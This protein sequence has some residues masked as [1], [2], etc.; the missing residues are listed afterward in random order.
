EYSRTMRSF[1][2][3]DETVTRS[4]TGTPVEFIDP[5]LQYP[6]GV[7]PN[8]F[9]QIDRLKISADVTDNTRLYT[10]LF[11]GDTKNRN[12]NTH[13]HFGGF[14]LRVINRSFDGLTLTGYTKWYEERNQKPTTFPEDDLFPDGRKPS[15]EVRHP[16]DR[17]RTTAGL[18]GSWRPFRCD[19]SWRSGLSLIG[20]YEYYS[21]QRRYVTY[22][23]IGAPGAEDTEFTQPDTFANVMH[24]GTQMQ[25][26]QQ[27]DTF[28]RYKMAAIDDPLF[29]V[30]ESD[31]GTVDPD[32]QLSSDITA[33]NTNQPRHEDIIQFGGNW[34]PT[35]NFLMS[36][37]VGI[38]IAS[39]RSAAARFDEA[40]YPI[41]LTAWYAPTCRWSL[42][43]GLAFY[44]NWIDQDITFGN[45]H[46]SSRGDE[47]QDTQPV[48]YTGRAFVVN[49]GTAY[50]CT[51]RLNLNGGFEFVRGENSF[52][53]PS[54][55]GA[56]WSK[57]GTFS[58]VLTETTRFWAGA[59][60]LLRDGISCYCYY[61]YYNWDDDAGNGESGNANM[62]LGGLS[63]VY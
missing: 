30:R 63:A 58:D 60:Y 50:A 56:D 46:S 27:C 23:I 38:E 32:L 15:E 25:W 36:A 9:T 12:R 59:D 22:E 14:D 8:N 62:F 18:K 5:T 10:N 16:V 13:R 21:I 2:A 34:T 3:N 42:S 6:Y 43:G 44:S 53:T 51:D 55:E 1:D 24:I 54:P 35:D 31:E 7:V 20:G 40:D 29:G 39:H 47:P 33:L 45:Q 26:S 52:V 37:W 28:I 17:E 49:L 11:L 61:N 19:N 57:L 41:V 48:D 4:Y